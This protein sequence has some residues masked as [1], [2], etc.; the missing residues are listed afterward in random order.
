MGEPISV[1][2]TFVGLTLTVVAGGLVH[3]KCRFVR[4]YLLPL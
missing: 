1:Q 4:R 2:Q 3:P